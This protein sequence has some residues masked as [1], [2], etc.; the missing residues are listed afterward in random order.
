MTSEQRMVIFASS[1]GT[2]FE[3]YDFYIYGTLALFL[4]TQFFSSVNPTAA[5]SSR[6]SPSP[7]ALRCGRSARCSSA[8]IGDMIGRKYT[9][10]VTM[11][12]MGVGTFFIGLLPG[13]ALGRHHRADRADRSAPGAGPR[14]RRRIW[15]RGDLRRRTCADEQARLLH[16]VDP[17]HRDARPV[18]GAAADPRHPHR[19]GRSR[20]RRLGLAHS[21]PA[22]GD[23]ARGVDLDPAASSTN[24]RCSADEG[25]RQAVRSGR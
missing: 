6:C 10:L 24:R 4:A 16:L 7:P 8:G 22:L 23:P 18:H 11:S 13:Y 12:L 17:D 21:V 3:W 19:D 5:S 20:L 9:F 14:A 25:R 2:V 1:L 15:R